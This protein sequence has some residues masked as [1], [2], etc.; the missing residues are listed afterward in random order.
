[1]ATAMSL[2]AVG[3]KKIRFH[4]Q[5]CSVARGGNQSCAM[6]ILA[7]IR[8]GQD[9]RAKSHA[10]VG[11]GGALAL[12]RTPFG[13]LWPRSTTA[14]GAH[15]APLQRVGLVLPTASGVNP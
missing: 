9:A 2:R 11:A 14:V 6:A 15:R 8:H 3:P 10:R 7:M 4:H 5:E 1:V 13:F 12:G